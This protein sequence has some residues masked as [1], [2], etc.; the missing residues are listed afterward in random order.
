MTSYSQRSPP[1]LW[2]KFN[3]G[4]TI[5]LTIYNS[6]GTAVIDNV[7]ITSGNGGAEV[8][9]SGIW[10]YT[11]SLTPGTSEKYAWFMTNGDLVCGDDFELNCPAELLTDWTH[12]SVS[13]P[14]NTRCLWNAARY[15]YGKIVPAA[16]RLSVYK[17]ND[18]D[19]A[20]EA[21]YTTGAG[22]PVSSIDPD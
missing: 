7:D 13:I 6:A 18:T 17:E 15:L 22:N 5:H 8:G 3:H 11:V 20:W 14:L 10:K 4:D 19:L 2:A 16:G 21:S 12:I 1:I 9:S